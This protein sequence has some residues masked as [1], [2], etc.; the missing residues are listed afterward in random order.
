MA[1]K[2][3][4]ISDV[5]KKDL[6]VVIYLLVFG[7]GTY[8]SQKYITDSEMLSIIIGAA[9]NY[10]VYRANQELT[11]NGYMKALK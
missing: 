3:I 2:K 7:G 8:V 9:L 6:K 1:V 5:L 4:T 10:V 11:N